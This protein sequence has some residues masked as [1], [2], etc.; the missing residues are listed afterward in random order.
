[1]K[2]DNSTLEKHSA[3]PWLFKETSS[4]YK[5]GISATTA[6]SIVQ[7]DDSGFYEK[8][9]AKINP[10][11]GDEFD[12]VRFDEKTCYANAELIVKAVNAYGDM[13]GLLESILNTSEDKG[14]EGCTYG[15]T[16]FDSPSAAYGFNTCLDSIKERIRKAI[17]KL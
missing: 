12:I 16:E 6:I 10:Q 11:S 5:N 13:L 3:L 14:R 2:T 17:P 4:T 8:T 15:D 9:I 7:I 1:M